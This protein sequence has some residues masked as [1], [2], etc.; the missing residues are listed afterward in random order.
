MNIT[1]SSTKEPWMNPKAPINNSL[2]LTLHPFHFRVFFL[3]S[4]PPI[5]LNTLIQSQ[6]VFWAYFSTWPI[7]HL[8]VCHED[9]GWVQLQTLGS[10]YKSETRSVDCRARLSRSSLSYFSHVEEQHNLNLVAL[11][12][13]VLVD[14]GF[15][16]YLRVSLRSVLA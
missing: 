13:R 4:V 10:S 6:V 11:G 2:E 12:P 16:T 7:V 3:F 8:H 14:A 5:L 9:Q 1:F 15:G